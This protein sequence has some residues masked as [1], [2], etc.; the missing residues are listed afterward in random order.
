MA[1][2]SFTASTIT[3][4]VSPTARAP[5]PPIAARAKS[6]IPE[7]DSETVTF[8]LVELSF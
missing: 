5:A 2:F 6:G 8:E 3:A 4:T 7:E 1:L